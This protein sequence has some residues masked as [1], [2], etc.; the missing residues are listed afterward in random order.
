VNSWRICS[1]RRSWNVDDER[2]LIPAECR[3]PG[4]PRPLTAGVPA[5]GR[6]GVSR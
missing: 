4:R 3:F 6:P 2:S 5:A 1:L